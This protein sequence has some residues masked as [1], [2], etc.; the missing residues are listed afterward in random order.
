ML[1]SNV[2]AFFLYIFISSRVLPS[3]LFERVVPVNVWLFSGPKRCISGVS[4]FEVMEHVKKETV[5]SWVGF[6]PNARWIP[7]GNVLVGSESQSRPFTTTTRRI[8][9]M[10]R[11]RDMVL[12]PSYYCKVECILKYIQQWY[13]ESNPV[14]RLK[15]QTIFIY[16]ELLVS[17]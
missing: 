9:L 14:T 15:V 11:F 16:F 6:C 1:Q 4:L 10:N 7:M 12:K 8:I 3:P 5:M 2:I 17:S 13:S